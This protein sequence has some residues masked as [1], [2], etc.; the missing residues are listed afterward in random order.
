MSYTEQEAD[1]FHVT[2]LPKQDG[3][4]VHMITNQEAGQIYAT[5]LTDQEAEEVRMIG[6][7]NQNVG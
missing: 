6:L 4:E 7:T 1:Y 2:R 5:S 3:E